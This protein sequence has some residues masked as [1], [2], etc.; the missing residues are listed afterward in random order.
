MSDSQFAIRDSLI[1]PPLWGKY[2]QPETAGDGGSPA[3]T[4]P[5]IV[6]CGHAASP[7]RGE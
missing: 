1:L 2:P 5:T 6:P 7:T 3:G 4:A